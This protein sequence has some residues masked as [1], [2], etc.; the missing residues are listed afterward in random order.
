MQSR[1][2]TL[3]WVLSMFA[4]TPSEA[5]TLKGWLPTLGG[6]VQTHYAIHYPA[7]TPVADVIYIHGFADT[8]DNHSPLFN[9]Y[10]Q[11]GARVLALDLPSHGR[12]RGRDLNDLSFEDLAA[13]V[14]EFEATFV[15]DLDRP[16]VINGWSTGG[17]LAV[18]M[19]QSSSFAQ[20][21]RPVSGLILHAPAVAVPAC[22]GS[23]ICTVTNNTLTHDELLWNRPLSPPSPIVKPLFATKL[24][25][26][27][28]Q[29]WNDT[30]PVSIPTFMIVG[31]E[32]EDR[33]VMTPKLKE[34][35]ERQQARGA[36]IHVEQIAGARHELDNELVEFGSVRVRNRSSAFLREVALKPVR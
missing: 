35:A 34:W 21:T 10:L 11:S 22:V 13:I 27:S 16:L 12:T 14:T 30:L 7:G 1:I 17:L 6:A 29:S 4:I 24:F 15:E 18:R 23:A 3:T 36:H 19:L 31:G 32:T 33:Y 9:A 25:W 26:N 28:L 2:F 20:F 5:R 8:K